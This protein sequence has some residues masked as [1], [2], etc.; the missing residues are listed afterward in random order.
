MRVIAPSKA[1]SCMLISQ[2]WHR[3]LPHSD[4]SVLAFLTAAFPQRAPAA[5]CA[6]PLWWHSLPLS[7]P[8]HGDFQAWYRSLRRH[9]RYCLSHCLFIISPVFGPAPLACTSCIHRRP[10]TRTCGWLVF[11]PFFQSALTVVHPYL[12]LAFRCLS[13]VCPSVLYGRWDYSLW[14]SC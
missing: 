8:Q 5:S 11:F 9:A 10:S 13:S 1:F 2:A 3:H 7:Y 12:R 14:L 4:A 6:L